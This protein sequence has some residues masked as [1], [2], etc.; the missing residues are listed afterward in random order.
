MLLFR[1]YWKANTKILHYRIENYS[2]TLLVE[3]MTSQIKPGNI[4]FASSSF[5]H[6][7][8]LQ[9]SVSAE[10]DFYLQLLKKLF[11]TATLAK[12]GQYVQEVKVLTNGDEV[13]NGKRSIQLASVATSKS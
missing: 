12:Q 3:R 10:H 5:S 13:F 6:V 2:A 11:K 4:K 8:T 9:C 1:R 7:I